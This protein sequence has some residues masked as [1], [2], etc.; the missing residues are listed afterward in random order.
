MEILRWAVL[1]VVAIGACVRVARVWSGTSHA[2]DGWPV[3]VRRA[4][5]TIVWFGSLSF[6]AGTVMLI[7]DPQSKSPVAYAAALVCVLAALCTVC[8]GA[9]L[10]TS[11][12]PQRLVP[13]GLRGDDGQSDSER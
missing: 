13:P 9:T 2:L 8:L 3:D 6:A 11:G 12:R 10:F 5:P 7:A 4:V 1:S